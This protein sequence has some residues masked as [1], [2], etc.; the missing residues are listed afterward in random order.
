MRSAAKARLIACYLPQFHP[1]PENDAWWGKGFTEWTNVAKS[2][3]LYQGHYQP[4]I[5]ADLGFYDLR[6]AESRIAQ[7]DLAQR[8][9]IEG[10][11]YWHYW[12]GG[13]KLL[14]KPFTEVLKSGA[15]D[16][17][18]CLGW[19]NESWT[20]IWHGSPNKMLMEQSYPGKK[21][22]ESHFYHVL[23]AFCDERYI[24]VEGK[25]VFY[26]YSPHKHPDS[27]AFIDHWQ[28]LALKEGLKG[29]YF[30]GNGRV[31]EH[32]NDGYDGLV[33][34]NPGMTFA[35][36]RNPPVGESYDVYRR[37]AE[38]E[39]GALWKKLFK[40]HYPAPTKGNPTVF[41]YEDFIQHAL[42]GLAADFDEYPCVLPN[43]DNTA[44]CGRRAH[45]LHG[46]TPELF[47][48]HLRQ[49]VDQVI[50]RPPEKRIVFVKS[51]NEWAE[52]NCLEPDMKFGKGY[53]EACREEILGSSDAV[54]GRL[55]HE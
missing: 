13:K 23:E 51:W 47:R 16:F 28:E 55:S 24:T 52:G 2:K 4:I 43:W 39:K 49:A 5:P 20:G 30:I 41:R 12:F 44:R 15:P 36:L 40:Q 50:N 37:L 17:P 7:A 6:V 11:L 8:H 53:L 45:I 29:I 3:P 32:C 14:E 9:G 46:S 10:F 1:I 19:A 22:E 31:A 25:P 18:F 35:K 42:P 27:R 34:P 33:Q 38:A 26:I 48:K 21:D 54:A